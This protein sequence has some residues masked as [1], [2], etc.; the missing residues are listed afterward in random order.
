V[1]IRTPLETRRLIL[2]RPSLEDFDRYFGM[3]KDPAVMRY[4]GDGSI[5]HWTREVALERFK[6]QIDIQAQSDVGPLAV[7]ARDPHH[8]LGWCA[9]TSSRFLQAVELGY[10]YSRDA[11]GYGYA[12]EAAAALLSETHRV[13]G[14]APLLACVHPRNG[15]SIRVL[16]KLGFVFDHARR[17]N[18][19]GCHLSV[20]R[21]DWRRFGNSR[22]EVTLSE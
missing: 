6:T 16:Q 20:Y 5:F 14:S 19:A 2:K 17:S 11:W 18:A 9:V 1:R 4:I 21:I 15:S 13:T 10:R 3:S 8:Y 7:Y 12:T 22:S